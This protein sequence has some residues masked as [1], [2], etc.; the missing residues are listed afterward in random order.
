MKI[1][2]FIEYWKPVYDDGAPPVTTT[3]TTNVPPVSNDPPSADP[4]P[5][6]SPKPGSFSEEQQKHVDKIVEKRVAKMKDEQQKTINQL[7]QIKKTK[8]LTEGERDKLQERINSLEQSVMTKEEIAARNKKE[9]DV[10][11]ETELQSLTTERDTWKSRYESS[12]I[13]R[14]IL[15]AAANKSDGNPAI[16]PGQIVT[17]LRENTLL[18]EDT[19]DGESTGVFVPRVKFAGRDSEG[20][21]MQMDLTVPEAVTEMKKMKSEYGNLWESGLTGGV[22]SNNEPGTG[23]LSDAVLTSQEAYMK[24][25]QRIKETI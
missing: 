5:A 23:A 17:I 8:D 22:G 4:P 20:K 14:S 16:N 18:V 10:K 12:T 24:D 1:N 13:E 6:D 19:V 9:A 15:D 3:T 2:D 7:N 11:H 25:R 21:P